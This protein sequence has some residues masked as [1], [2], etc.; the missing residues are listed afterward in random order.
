MTQLAADTFD[1]ANNSTLGA[2]WSVVIGTFFLTSNE[3]QTQ[4]S[5]GSLAYYNGVVWPADQYSEIVVGS[6]VE[7][8][9]DNG[10][11]AAVRLATGAE[12]CYFVQCSTHETRLYRVISGTFLQL[13]SDGP[14]CVPGDTVRLIVSGN[15]LTVLKNNVS[16]ITA[17]DSNISSGNSGIWGDVSALFSTL[18][19][20]TGGNLSSGVVE[21]DLS[22]HPKQEIRQLTT[23]DY[24]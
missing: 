2:L 23:G 22:E 19:S 18:A 8:T 17:T 11:G 5:S 14:V 15:A 21:I 7:T 16:I 3:A 9:T 20:W 13:G 12:T 10:S 4:S 24:A 1:R 6:I